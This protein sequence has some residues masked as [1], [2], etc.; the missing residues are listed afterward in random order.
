MQINKIL[1][2]NCSVRFD[3]LGSWKCSSCNHLVVCYYTHNNRKCSGINGSCKNCVSV[4]S[5]CYSKMVI[6]VT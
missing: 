5:K 2:I 6:I 3:F 1:N 4:C